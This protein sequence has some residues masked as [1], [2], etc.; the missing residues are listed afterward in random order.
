MET[1]SDDGVIE[2]AGA[3]AA[4]IPKNCQVLAEGV[5][6]YSAREQARLSYLVK[7][8]ELVLIVRVLADGSNRACARV[9]LR[10]T[11]APDKR[12]WH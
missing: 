5:F 10:P 3:G 7:T 9:M 4:L 12:L 2:V 6:R 8:D 1:G 11:R